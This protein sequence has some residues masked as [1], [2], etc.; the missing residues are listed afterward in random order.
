MCAHWLCGKRA[1]PPTLTWLQ[2]RS[3]S[4]CLKQVPR[5]ALLAVAVTGRVW[6]PSESC[7][8]CLKDNYAPQS[9]S[10]TPWCCMCSAGTCGRDEPSFL[11]SA[12][13]PFTSFFVSVSVFVSVLAL[14]AY[15]CLCHKTSLPLHPTPSLT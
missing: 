7:C 4:A 5:G 12:P 8:K 2:L 14:A 6:Q 10:V 15:N 3:A 11:A 13:T 9:Q 1:K